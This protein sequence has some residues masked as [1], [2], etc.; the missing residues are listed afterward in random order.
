MAIVDCE[1]NKWAVNWQHRQENSKLVGDLVSWCTCIMLLLTSSRGLVVNWKGGPL[2]Y[3]RT[4]QAVQQR[5]SGIWRVQWVREHHAEQ[6]TSILL[7]H[8]QRTGAI[9]YTHAHSVSTFRLPHV[10][11]IHSYTCVQCVYSLW[12]IY[13]RHLWS[14]ANCIACNPIEHYNFQS[15]FGHLQPQPIRMCANS[16]Y[17]CSI[18]CYPY[19]FSH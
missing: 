18:C 1:P 17:I 6:T 14:N 9:A 15:E 4:P 12:I 2:L 5:W 7:H 3:L 10:V 19:V 11:G 13:C 16:L 8:L